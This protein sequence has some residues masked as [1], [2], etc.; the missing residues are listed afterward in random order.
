MTDARFPERWLNDR[1]LIRLPDDAFRLFAISLMW[2]VANKTDGELYDDDL[3]LIPSVDCG[4]AGQLVKAGLWRRSGDRWLIGDF[5]ETQSTSVDLALMADKR[6][7]ARDKK[8]RQRA[9]GVTSP[10][11]SPGTQLGQDRPGQ[12]ALR[13]KVK[14]I[15][16]EGDFSSSADHEVGGSE[17]TAPP[18]SGNPPDHDG[19]VQRADDDQHTSPDVHLPSP[20]DGGNAREACAGCG[21]PIPPGKH[22]SAVYCDRKCKNTASKRRSRQ[23]ITEGT[24]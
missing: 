19:S 24:R 13:P 6:R 9:A 23:P 5:E 11:T 21:Q 12:A 7:R 18:Q 10:G 8:R 15:R 22:P 4:C 14:S 20:A 3:S 16:P 17:L 2:S 1:R